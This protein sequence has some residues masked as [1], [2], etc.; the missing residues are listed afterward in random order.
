[1]PVPQNAP[2]VS[3]GMNP[4]PISPRENHALPVQN[5]WNGVNVPDSL[6]GQCPKAT[7]VSPWYGVYLRALEAGIGTVL[8]F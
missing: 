8:P 4:V 2:C 7:D 6:Q 5:S 1:Y 3:A